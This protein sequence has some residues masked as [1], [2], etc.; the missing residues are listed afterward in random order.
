MRWKGS[1]NE[2][3]RKV[4][5]IDWLLEWPKFSPPLLES[6]VETRATSKGEHGV[7]QTEF[8]CPKMLCLF[9]MT[10]F[11]SDVTLKGVNFSS[12]GLIKNL[13]EQLLSY[14]W[15]CILVSRIKKVITESN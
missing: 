7:I 14:S 2:S 13:S 8:I 6:V 11:S 12:K 3:D 9:S 15:K 1:G 10:Y 4:L 5:T